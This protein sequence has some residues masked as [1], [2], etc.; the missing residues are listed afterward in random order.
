MRKY[1]KIAGIVVAGLCALF[2][3]IGVIGV[4]LGVDEESSG[5]SKADSVAKPIQD[6]GEAAERKFPEPKPEPAPEPAPEPEPALASEPEPELTSAQENAVESAQSYLDTMGFSKAGLIQQLSSSAGEG[7]PR[8]DAVFAANH[9][10]VD[11]NE[12]AVESAQSY[13]D[14]MPFSRDGLIDQLTSSAGEGFTLA[15]A[16]YAVDQVY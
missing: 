8:A 11:W 9:V 12:E 14:T 3:A 2:V 1:L 7:F 10:D 6:A 15:Q 5:K 13:L 4:A 16:Q